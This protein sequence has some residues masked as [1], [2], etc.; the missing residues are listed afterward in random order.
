MMMFCLFKSGTPGCLQEGQAA[1][2]VPLKCSKPRAT[3][4]RH[5]A[6][7][8]LTG[9]GAFAPHRASHGMGLA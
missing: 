9:A 3:M 2:G 6:G 4:G 5:W 1:S 7:A 8:L